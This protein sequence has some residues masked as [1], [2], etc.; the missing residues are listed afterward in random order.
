M[1]MTHLGHRDTTLIGAGE[2]AFGASAVSASFFVRVITAVV[3]VIA[4]PR[5]EDTTSISAT[6]LDRPASVEGTIALVFVGIVT[7]IVVAIAGPQT[8]NAF[9]VGAIEFVAFAS[10]VATDAHPVVVDQFSGFVALAF[11]RCVGRRMARLSASTVVQSA[12][13][14]LAT[15][16]IR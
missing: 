4:L 15:L 7:A 1:Q 14:E 8:R 16:A 10:Q 5:P 12:R 6:V 11:G 13:I 3:F 2:F 9:A